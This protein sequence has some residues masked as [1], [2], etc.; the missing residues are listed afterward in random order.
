MDLNTAPVLVALVDRL[1]LVKAQ[2]AQLKTEEDNLKDVL[3]ESGQ[4]FVEGTLHRVA[5]THNAARPSIDWRAVAEHFSPSR[6]LVVAH[7]S[8]GE[9]FVTVRV[10]ARKTS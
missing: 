2:I 7:T 3:A 8:H 5:I 4:P 6:Q 1:A 9:P 10:S